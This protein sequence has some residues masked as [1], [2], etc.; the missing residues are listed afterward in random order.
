MFRTAFVGVLLASGCAIQAPFVADQDDTRY[1]AW[2]DNDAPHLLDVTAQFVY[3]YSDLPSEGSA[4]RTPW[5]GTY[6]PVYKD[7]INDTWDG[8]GTTPPSTKFGEA[9]GVDGIEDLVS[10][11]FGVDSRE[12]KDKECTENSECDDGATCSKRAGEDAGYCIETWF[13]LCHAWAPAAVM[14]PEPIN[15]VTHNGVMFKVND[16]TALVTAGLEGALEEP[17]CAR[18]HDF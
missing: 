7:S 13:G 3:T 2:E 17:A 14:E 15:P 4:H 1:K 16:I 18:I 6:W 11:E 10:N 5:A 9:F 8:A 12:G